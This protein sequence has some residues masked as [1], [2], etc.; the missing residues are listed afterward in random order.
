MASM[1]APLNPRPAN[2]SMAAATML[3]RLAA[4]AFGLRIA[5]LR[6]LWVRARASP[7]GIDDIAS[8]F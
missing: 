1:L 5:A 7:P 4:G 6:S 3:A 8:L 2:S